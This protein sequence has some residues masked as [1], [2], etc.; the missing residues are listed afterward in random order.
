[1]TFLDYIFLPTVFSCQAQEVSIG[2][3]QL[4][5]KKLH[6][7]LLKIKS[8][9]VLTGKY[10]VPPEHFLLFMGCCGWYF[11]SPHNDS[12]TD[13]SSEKEPC[14]PP[15]GAPLC[16]RHTPR[17]PPSRPGVLFDWCYLFMWQN[18]VIK[19]TPHI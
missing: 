2:P 9:S 6:S 18:S 3:F 13:R 19:T 1:M 11:S 5:N 10:P 4:N 17:K 7:H 12:F 16:R 15:P 8:F 14:S